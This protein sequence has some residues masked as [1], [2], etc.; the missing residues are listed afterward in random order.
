MENVKV[1]QPMSPQD[2]LKL[3]VALRRALKARVA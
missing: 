3:L 2:F 1:P